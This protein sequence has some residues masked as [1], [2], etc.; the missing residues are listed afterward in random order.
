MNNFNG[1][2]ALKA[3]KALM[4]E[5]RKFKKAKD[6]SLAQDAATAE[7]AKARGDVIQQELLYRKLT[8]RF[9]ESLERVSALEIQIREMKKK[10][11]E[12]NEG[13]P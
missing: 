5:L 6:G 11:D 1:E 8:A 13:R 2:A 9:E 3:D 4:T 7:L 10:V 12:H